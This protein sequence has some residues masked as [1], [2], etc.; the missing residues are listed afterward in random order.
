MEGND[1]ETS[2]DGSSSLQ[3]GQLFEDIQSLV[4]VEEN[5]ADGGD[6]LW[7]VRARRKEDS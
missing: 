4:L 6:P 7:V 5:N 3:P 2:T 1:T